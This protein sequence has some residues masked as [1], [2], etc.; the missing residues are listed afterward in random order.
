MEREL[1]SRIRHLVVCLAPPNRNIAGLVTKDQGRAALGLTSQKRRVVHRKWGLPWTSFSLQER[2]LAAHVN[3]PA[4]MKSAR[5][6]MVG[7][8]MIHRELASVVNISSALLPYQTQ[9]VDRI[10]LDI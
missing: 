5:P 6:S 8:V 3:Q 4:R 2:F 10:F 1:Q 7:R 9:Q